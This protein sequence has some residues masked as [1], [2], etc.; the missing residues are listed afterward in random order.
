MSSF[1]D[2]NLCAPKNSTSKCIRQNQQK[3]IPL[4]FSY[5]S[6]ISK[7]E[8]PEES[9]KMEI[10]KIRPAIGEIKNRVKESTSIV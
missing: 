2:S 6:C 8:K 4:Y 3:D 7:T 9:R 5:L 10:I 1:G